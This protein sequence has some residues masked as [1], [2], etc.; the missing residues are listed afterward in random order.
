MKTIFFSAAALFLSC[1]V[2]MADWIIVQKSSADGQEKELTM[3]IKD[4][5]RALTEVG[6]EVSIIV[7]SNTANATILMHDQKAVMKMDADKMKNL[8]G[9]AAKALGGGQEASKPKATG[10]KEK[11]GEW[12]TEIYEWEGSVGK[13]TFWVATDFP[14]AAELNKIQDKLSTALG[15]PTAGL[16]PSNADFPGLVVKSQMVMMGKTIASE[17]LSVNDKAT[18]PETDFVT[19]QDYQE[20]KMPSIPGAGGQ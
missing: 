4:D 20:M 14:K 3:K 13:G 1:Q 12:E 16:I 6:K 18:V 8:V 5:G 11:V 7:D 10:K 2:T 15:S 19:P 9:M 17:T